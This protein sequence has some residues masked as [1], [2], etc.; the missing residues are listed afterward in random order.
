MLQWLDDLHAVTYSPDNN[1]QS[2]EDEVMRRVE[3]MVLN[4]SDEP[5]RCLSEHFACCLSH[6]VV[7]FVPD[8]CRRKEKNNCVTGPLKFLATCAE[9]NMPDVAQDT[10]G[11]K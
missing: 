3:M 4:P 8:C 6:I 5:Q 7:G 1:F 2:V 9:H 10:L 11:T